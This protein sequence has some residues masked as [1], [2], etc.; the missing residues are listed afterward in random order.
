VRA[1]LLLLLLLPALASAQDAPVVSAHWEGG[2][3]VVAWNAPGNLYR[4]GADGVVVWL[5]RFAAAGE[6]T[7]GGGGDAA[8]Q[9]RGGDRYVLKHPI[10]DR[11]LGAAE[12]E[13][14]QVI[15]PVVAKPPG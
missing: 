4:V 12:L 8:Y 7:L 15:L 11:V 5:G 10:E 9:P 3:A 14:P 13:R 6:L 2:R 1:L